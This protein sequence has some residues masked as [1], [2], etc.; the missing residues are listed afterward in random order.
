MRL[1]WFIDSFYSSVN[2]FRL[3]VLKFLILLRSKRI[4]FI[5]FIRT[6]NGSDFKNLK[7]SIKKAKHAVMDHQSFTVLDWRKKEIVTN[8]YGS[9]EGVQY[10]IYKK[11]CSLHP[12]WLFLYFFLAD[13]TFFT[14]FQEILENLSRYIFP[15]ISYETCFVNLLQISHHKL[16]CKSWVFP[17]VVAFE[18]ISSVHVN[19]SEM[20]RIAW[21]WT[22]YQNFSGGGSPRHPVHMKFLRR[23][24]TSISRKLAR[25]IRG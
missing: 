12:P 14:H 22:F 11:F 17:L 6:R 7:I 8:L 20:F 18:Y 5:V 4:I 23:L 25:Q 19:Q 16:I 10:S 21:F 2:L 3:H 13:F 9:G 24:N 1:I 15:T